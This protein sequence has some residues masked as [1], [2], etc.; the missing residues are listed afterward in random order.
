MVVPQEG[1]FVGVATEDSGRSWL[2]RTVGST[3]SQS[4][5]Y[6]VGEWVPPATNVE[7]A[8]QL[9][10]GAAATREGESAAASTGLAR[11]QRVLGPLLAER[12]Q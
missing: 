4:R 6:V 5:G 7:G 8:G 9:P 11:A 12:R 1:D 10:G 3:S 2:Q